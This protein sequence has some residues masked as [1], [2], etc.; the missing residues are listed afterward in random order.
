MSKRTTLAAF[1]AAVIVQVLILLGVPARQAYTLATGR[2]VVLK[3]EPV[4]PYSILSGYYVTLGF[5]ISRLEAFSNAVDF[6]WQEACYA[7][8]ERGEDGVWKPLSLERELPKN[9][10]ENH[11]A[12]HGRIRY[13]RIDYGIEAFYIPETRR[14]AIESDLREN[15]NKAQVEIKVDSRGNAALRQLRIE[16]RVYE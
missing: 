2:S 6:E 8:L 15:Q 11:I 13:G 14:G 5:D 10:P 9:L 12:I 7:V 3:V 4:D 1:V 16:D